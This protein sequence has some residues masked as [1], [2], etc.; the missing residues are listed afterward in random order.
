VAD[1]RRNQPL[2]QI[3]GRK[4]DST[5]RPSRQ[6]SS[7][8]PVPTSSSVSAAVMSPSSPSSNSAEIASTSDVCREI[9]RPDV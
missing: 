8:M 5:T 1:S 3:S 4:P 9:T 6:S 2:S 7:S